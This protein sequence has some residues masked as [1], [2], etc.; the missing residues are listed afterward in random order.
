M[1]LQLITLTLAGLFHIGLSSSAA[2]AQRLVDWPIRTTAMPDAIVSDAG[3]VFW[4][5]AGLTIGTY[6]GQGMLVSLRT[7]EMLDLSGMAGVAAARFERTVLAL[8]FEHVGVDGFTRTDDSPAGPQF[9]VGENQFTLAAS[10]QVGSVLTA[11]AVARY[12]RDDLAETDATISVGAG[13]MLEPAW[14]LRPRIGAYALSVSDDVAWGGAFEL[15]LPRFLGPAYQL[16]LAYG[17]QIDV[18]ME[19][20]QHRIAT[21]LDWDKHASLSAGLTREPGSL[22]ASWSPILAASLQL[23]RYTL[24]VV[25][26]SLVNE[27]G[28]S[29]TFRLQG[30]LGP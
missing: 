14:P 12:A 18:H 10:R 16:G 4:N 2:S 26:E 7:P 23:N 9:D 5:P 22:G 15:R 3:A 29:S 21:R 6:R 17:A 25:R 19:S 30:G 11:G 13:V 8:A 27:F 24:G 20:P 28:A 1:H